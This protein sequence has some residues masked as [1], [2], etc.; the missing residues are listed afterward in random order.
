MKKILL[1][2]SLVLSGCGQTPPDTTPS[3]QVQNQQAEAKRLVDADQNFTN[4]A[5]NE[6]YR[7]LRDNTR[8]ACIN[9]QQYLFWVTTPDS[10]FPVDYHMPIVPLFENNH[11]LQCRGGI[12]KQLD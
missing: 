4:R 11:T 6:L 1:L 5:R 10:S 3:S 8:I 7:G 9:G 12:T 2:T